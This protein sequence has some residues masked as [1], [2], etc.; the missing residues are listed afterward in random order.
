[1]FARYTSGTWGA[2]G[3]VADDGAADLNP[4]VLSLPSGDAACI[5]QKAN[6]VLEDTADLTTF[7]S[8]LEVVVS[9]Y[10]AAGGT[11]SAPARLTT[12]DTLDRSPF[13]AAASPTDMLA[14]WVNNLANDTLGS[15]TAPNSLMWSHFDGTAWSAPATIATGL[16]TVLDVTT[17]YDGTT[18]ALVYCTDGDDNLDTTAD[19]ELWAAT[20]NGGIWTAPTR[21][22]N[23][24]VV[25]TSPRLVYDTPGVLHLAWLKGDD[26]RM[27]PG[28]DVANSALIVAP[29]ESLG[30]KDFD[31]VGGPGGRLAFVWNDA[32][33]AGS[34]LYAIYYDPTLATRSQ[35]RQLTN[36]DAS[37]RFASGAF[38]ASGSLMCIYDKNHTVYEDRQEVVNG[39]TVTVKNVPKAGQS[40]LY[41]LVQQMKADLAVS[42]Q[43]FNITPSNPAPGAAALLTA[44]V[45][46]RGEAPVANAQ[47]AFYDGDPSQGSILIGTTQTIAGPLAGG[48]DATVSVTWNVP[49]PAASHRLYVVVDPAQILDDRDRTNN[50]ASFATMRAD[51]QVESITVQMAGK[52]RIVTVRVSNSSSLAV[53]GTQV[54][55]RRNGLT[56]PILQTL[57]VRA[58]ASSVQEGARNSMDLPATC[59]AVIF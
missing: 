3:S 54:E 8:H 58:K 31:L 11:W 49:S 1:M 19:Q 33:A 32:S 44:K 12:N 6:A 56:G 24:S 51:L 18:G 4:Q 43:D 42:V 22:T 34:D 2:A 55:I 38:D 16:G 48:T 50:I 15:A 25:D 45:T 5:W 17:A 14:V 59:S 47:V 9:M 23:D 21:L 28:T 52:D 30:G 40:D 20:Y 7:L 53:G 10:S 46:S 39:Q 29:G 41:F 37:E 27:A 35:P 13:L 26:Y 57:D 36:D